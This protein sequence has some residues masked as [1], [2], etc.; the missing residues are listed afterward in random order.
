MVKLE[1]NFNYYLNR[2]KKERVPKD[3]V[4]G[5]RY[6]MDFTSEEGELLDI[7]NFAFMQVKAYI[8]GP[9]K[10]QQKSQQ[11]LVS[12][13]SDNSFVLSSLFGS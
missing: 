13:L 4:I 6:T 3:I 11:V 10:R 8:D 5:E 9:K 12:L 7:E 1:T 2:F